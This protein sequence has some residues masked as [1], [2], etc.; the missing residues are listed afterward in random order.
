MKIV[1]GG[2]KLELVS[3][4]NREEFLLGCFLLLAGILFLCS[5]PS[6]YHQ[7]WSYRF[8]AVPKWERVCLSTV[9][10]LF[11]I[12]LLAGAFYNLYCRTVYI[13]DLVRKALTIDSYPFQTAQKRNFKFDEIKGLLHATAVI[14]PG[15]TRH[16]IAIQFHAGEPLYLD[17]YFDREEHAQRIVKTVCDATLI[18]MERQ[19]G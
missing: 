9:A 2:N 7:E 6:V 3:S 19:G 17:E 1:A 15:K 4:K 16:W 5:I 13:F 14:A 18:P 11:G 8:G 12:F 10:F